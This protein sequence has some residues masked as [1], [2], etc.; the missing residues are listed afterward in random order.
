MLTFIEAHMASPEFRRIR[1]VAEDLGFD[2]GQVARDVVPCFAVVRGFEDTADSAAIP[3][4]CSH[5]ER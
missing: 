1:I 2:T 4:G 3:R 5:P